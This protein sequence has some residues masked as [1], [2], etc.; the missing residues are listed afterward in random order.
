HA[1]AAEERLHRDDDTR[2]E[3]RSHRLLVERDQAAA[4]TARSAIAVGRDEAAA[5]VVPVIDR[6]IDR[7]DLHFEHV[8][9]LGPFDVYRP[10]KNVSAGP[11]AGITRRYLGGDSS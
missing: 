9:W 5:A 8:A 2:H 6:E 4:L 1:H 3:L 10:G 7:Q 11:A